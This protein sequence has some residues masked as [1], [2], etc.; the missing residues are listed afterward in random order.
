MSAVSLV[1]TIKIAKNISEVIKPKRG[2]W[3]HHSEEFIITLVRTRRSHYTVTAKM[4]ILWGAIVAISM[5]HAAVGHV[6]FLIISPASLSIIEV[7]FRL[8]TWCVFAMIKVPSPCLSAE[9]FYL[10]TS[11]FL[12]LFVW[13][14][15]ITKLIS[16]I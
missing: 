6:I 4:G 1:V 16:R 10:Q 12:L 8:M 5:R 3:P 9:I 14:Y 13:F 11:I 2:S 15:L 7:Q